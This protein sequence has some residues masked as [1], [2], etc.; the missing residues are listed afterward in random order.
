MYDDYAL[1]DGS[2]WEVFVNMR[3][4]IEFSKFETK[5]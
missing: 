2:L 1:I 5:L 3:F 4:A